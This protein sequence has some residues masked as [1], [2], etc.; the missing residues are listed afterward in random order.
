[1]C[2]PTAAIA[3]QT[4]GTVSS[5]VGAFYGAQG[6][7]AALGAQAAT[8]EI[9]A[10]LAELT[11]Q[12]ALRSGQLEEQRVRLNTANLK[13]KQ[14]TT[15]A[16]NGVDLTSD[17]AVNI[18]TTTDTMGEIDANTTAA[19]AARAAWGY[20]VQGMNYQNEAIGARATAK[21]ISPFMAAATTALTGAGDVAMTRYKLGKEGALS[22]DS[23][24][25]S[26]GRDTKAKV[27]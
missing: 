27:Y 13:S 12:S 3:L 23:W 20:R 10:K 8:A 21:G 4:A 11:A 22:K 6:Q 5:T 26:L 7:K 2:D 18:L 16:A 1:M 24:W 9:N 17:S 15:M 19:N 14:R 25:N